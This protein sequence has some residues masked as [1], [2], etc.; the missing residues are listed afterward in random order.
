ML[1][2]V[3]CGGFLSDLAH[4]ALCYV[5]FICDA[6]FYSEAVALVMFALLPKPWFLVL[7]RE[8]SVYIFKL[9]FGTMFID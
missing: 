6:K 8:A 9:C 7:Y 3:L 2:D 5:M 4:F 1:R